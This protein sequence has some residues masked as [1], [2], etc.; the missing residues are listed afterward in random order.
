MSFIPLLP[1]V[2]GLFTMFS[3]LADPENTVFRAA[4]IIPFTAP[5]VMPVRVAM[6]PVPMWEFALSVAL[7]IVTVALV[8]WVAGK[9][10]SIGILATGKRPSMGE[11]WRWIRTA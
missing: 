2:L 5:M 9:I 11:V 10:Y 7:L 1:L 4:S 3:G 8:T 6:T